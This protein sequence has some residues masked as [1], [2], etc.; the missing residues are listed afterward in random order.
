MNT[1]LVRTLDG[2]SGLGVKVWLSLGQLVLRDKSE[3]LRMGT[4]RRG[5]HLGRGIVPFSATDR[6]GSLQGLQAPTTCW[7]RARWKFGS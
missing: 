4:D 1:E 3:T 2:Q 5:G 7:N 6:L